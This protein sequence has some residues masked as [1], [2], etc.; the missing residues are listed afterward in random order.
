MILKFLVKNTST[1]EWPCLGR[2]GEVML[3]SRWI[4]AD[5][6]AGAQREL[7]YDVEPGD[8]VGL[9]L[10]VNPPGVPRDYWLE[11]DLVQKPATWFSEQGSTAWRQKVKILAP[12]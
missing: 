7:P 6:T 9:S 5:G 3:E 10:D 12:D 11:V 8:T 1:S 2:T 4:D